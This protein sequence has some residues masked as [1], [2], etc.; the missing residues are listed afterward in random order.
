MQEDHE[1]LPTKLRWL[2]VGLT[3][4]AYWRVSFHGFINYDDS[5]FVA[6]NP[7]VYTGL[8]LANLKWAFTTLSGDATSY[9]PLVWLTH[10]LD[11]ELFGLRAGPQHL[12][13]L[14]LHVANTVLLFTVL[15][16]L[17]GKPWRSAVVAA[18]FALHPLHVQT[19][20]WISERKS[21]VCTL[22]WLLT[23]LAYMRYV[24]RGGSRN[25][26][27]VLLLFAAALLSKPIAVSL[28]I[29]LLL[30]DFW[31]LARLPQIA[32]GETGAPIV[33]PERPLNFADLRRRFES[34][35]LEKAPLFVLS[36]LA[37]GVTVVAQSDLSAI[38]PLAE[39]PMGVRLS[40][41][42]VA[43]AL[44][45]RKL[46]W[47]VDLSPIYPL[48][49]DWAWWQVTGA[50]MLL[51][52]ISL[53][54][55]GQ[56]RRQPYLLVGWCWYLVTLVPT[57]GFVQ[58]GLQGMA[59][60][61]SYVPLMGL[62]LLTVW[63]VSERI[64]GLR[65]ARSVLGIGAAAATGACIL[66]TVVN[67][68]YWQGSVPL[69]EHAVRVTRNNFI[70]HRQLGMAY[71]SNGSLREAE[72]Q[73]RESLRI[74]PNRAPTHTRLGDVLFQEG[75]SQSAFEQYSLALKLKPRDAQAHRKLA[76]LFMRS[77]DAGFHDPRKAL[78]HAR[79]ACDLNH[80]RKRDLVAFLAQVCAE[81][82]E[83]QQA[84]AAA[85][86]ALALSVG[87]QEIQAAMELVTNVCR[88]A[89]VDGERI[90]PR[91]SQVR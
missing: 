89:A 26:L 50:G 15:D 72:K 90:P 69:F 2:L 30:L 63:E 76:E 16:K 37:C 51:L 31:P 36:G 74:D 25:Y 46:V 13:N 87:P 20:A 56:A 10:Q 73:Y 24:R 34:L 14:W 35:L 32:T 52:S 28:P 80:Y 7:H 23:T 75:D 67:V 61:Y 1:T 68:Q 53:W 11:C 86:K 48:R 65:H 66:S 12:T 38:Q 83:A 85:Q 19:V 8:T 45:L 55:A 49:H 77:P 33:L 79:L 82:H 5:L 88:I 40:N 41:S 84:T 47:P 44:Y 57:L 60:R 9:Q 71:Q 22:F 3:A 39:V 4:A 78:E 29:T 17:T 6:A 21:L 18:L 62:F 81:N 27:L 43:C 91:S 59:D 58:V 70:A 42:V 54:V 64:A